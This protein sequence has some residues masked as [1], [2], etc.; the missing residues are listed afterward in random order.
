MVDSGNRT[1]TFIYGRLQDQTFSRNV[2][3]CRTHD[4]A[5][6]SSVQ[7]SALALNLHWFALVGQCRTMQFDAVWW[8]CIELQWCDFQCNPMQMF[9]Q[10]LCIIFHCCLHRITLICIASHWTAL[11]YTELHRADSMQFDG[12]DCASYFSPIKAVIH[13]CLLHAS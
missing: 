2:V 13:H 5:Q 7:F 10:V 3:Q 12:I 6:C 9:W 8:I 1:C 11:I 4:R